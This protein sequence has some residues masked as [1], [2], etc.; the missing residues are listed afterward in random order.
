MAALAPADLASSSHWTH[1]SGR[2][3]LFDAVRGFSVASMVL[4][5][6]CYDLVFIYGVEVPFFSGLFVDVWRATI[7][8]TFLAVS[9]WMCSFSKSN[10]VRSGRY[11]A[12]AAL[13]FVATSLA[14]VDDPIN[15]G[16]VFCI[17]A[18]TL[19]DALLEKA[20]LEPHG[21]LVAGCLCVAFLLCLNVPRGSFG[22][23]FFSVELPAAW[24]GTPWL[25]WL[26]FPGPGFVSG[27]YYP[28][29]PF[30][31]MY[32]AGIAT[33]RWFK[34]RGY[35]SWVL[36]AH[37]RPLEWLGRHALPIYV[38]HQPALMAL[39]WLLGL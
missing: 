3:R 39:F 24:Y 14:A 5:H 38:I 29:V 7:A 16:I 11:L 28:L 17:G 12:I 26:G 31:L 36:D 19:V 13:I 27:D 10:L 34:T 23:P 20:G 1:P 2:V 32:G 37:C 18:A 15:F 9:G 33:G 22:G 6:A 8:W 35:P 4:F 21:L 30:A 25:A